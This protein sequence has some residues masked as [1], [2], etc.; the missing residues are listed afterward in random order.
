MSYLKP[1]DDEIREILTRSRVIA[2]VGHSDKPERTSYQIAKFLQQAG[3]TVYPVNPTV[4]QIEGQPCYPCLQEVPESVDI[5]NVFRRSD[6]L[7]GIVHEAIAIQARTLWAQI[8]IKD[9]SAA[10]QALDWGLNVV[11]DA[12]IKVE[13]FRLNISRG[14]NFQ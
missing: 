12:C 8:G 11:M 7:S 13:Y 2:V 1:R 14:R 9:E 5:V 4:A 10:Q 6:Q 3:Y